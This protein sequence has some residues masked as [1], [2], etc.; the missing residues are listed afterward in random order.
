[1][2]KAPG[3]TARV[4]NSSRPLIST[5]RTSGRSSAPDRRR[6]SAAIAVVA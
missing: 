3:K 4:K 6:Q 5:S 2:G 1:M